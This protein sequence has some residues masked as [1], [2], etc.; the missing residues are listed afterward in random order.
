[1]KL[2]LFYQKVLKVLPYFNVIPA[3]L[4][5][6]Y[7]A[8]TFIMA[9]LTKTQMSDEAVTGFASFAVKPSI[10]EW[11]GN[12]EWGL[13]LPLP[14]LLAYLATY[15]ELV[16]GFLL[17]IGLF[18]R[19]ISLPLLFTMI[20]AMTTVHLD[21]G[22]FAITPTN[23]QT[24][25]AVVYDWVGIDAAAQ[26]L[27]NSAQTSVRL[28]RMRDILDENGNT[29]WLYEKGSIVVLNNGIEFAMTYFIMLLALIFMGAG[30]WLS[31]D[32]Y[33]NKYAQK[34]F[35]NESL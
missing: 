9:G 7:L 1:M 17:L 27:E 2:Y 22:W 26:S 34:R 16:G 11:F 14:D 21:N 3:T 20:I 6:L 12:A 24:S 13:G 19:L 32:Y 15:T 10:I 18:T 29:D 4:I 25:P 35:A 5:R 30:R 28:N 23:P 8:P 31:V 33:L